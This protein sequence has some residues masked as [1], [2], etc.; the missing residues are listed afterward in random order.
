M[1][2][3]A[4]YDISSTDKEAFGIK[5]DELVG[6]FKNDIQ[7][8]EKSLYAV[9]TDG[10][11]DER[12]DGRSAVGELAFS[13]ESNVI[14]INEVIPEIHT[15]DTNMTGA[16]SRMFRAAM[17]EWIGSQTG[18]KAP[19]DIVAWVIDK[20]LENP[21]NPSL[22]VRILVNK[23]QLDSLATTIESI[24]GAGLK[25]QVAGG[26]FF[27]SLQAATAMIA[28]DP[29]MVKQAKRM[30]DT[31]LVPEFLEGLPYQSQLMA[32]TNELWSSWSADEQTEFINA[33]SSKVEAYRDIHNSP[34]AWIPLNK[35]DDIDEW[36]H[37]LTLDLLP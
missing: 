35:G 17:V 29:N 12:N 5:T 28:R 36:V 37:P 15:S 19:R 2:D 7:R 31:G 33:L 18:A 32:I 11:V 16:A 3:S 14:D 30:A 6:Q 24:L 23:R 22:E 25:A 21:D 9:R 34:E 8:L 10:T 1:G 4:F 27:T 13:D 26:D 20:D